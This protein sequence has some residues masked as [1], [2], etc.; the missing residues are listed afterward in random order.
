M[1]KVMRVIFS[2]LVITAIFCS[3]ALA[4]LCG[5]EPPAT[6]DTPADGPSG[7]NGSPSIPN[8]P[9]AHVA[10][11]PGMQFLWNQLLANTGNISSL[12]S[13]ANIINAV[14]HARETGDSSQLFEQ[15]YAVLFPIFPSDSEIARA[16]QDV[17]DFLDTLNCTE[18]CAELCSMGDPHITTADGVRYSFQAVGEFTTLTSD[19]L[20]TELQVRYAPASPSSRSV[21]AGSAIALRVGNSR[22]TANINRE[23]F[24]KF[25]GVPVSLAIGPESVAQ[26]SSDVLLMQL[27]ENFYI[28]RT[29]DGLE[30]R[31]RRQARNLNFGVILP[32]HLGNTFNGIFGSQDDNKENEF[33]GR[34]GSVYPHESGKLSY[35]DLYHGFGNSWRVSQENS[36]FDYEDGSTTIDYTDLTFPDKILTLDD[37]SQEDRARAEKVCRDIGAPEGWMM[38]NCIYDVGF[39][40]DDN[41]AL[42]YAPEALRTSGQLPPIFGAIT[43]AAALT[44]SNN[45][46]AGEK[47]EVSWDIAANKDDAITIENGC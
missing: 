42:G 23:D 31:F 38:D 8:L 36:L 27:N 20:D 34:D 26:L 13:M 35:E 47:F 19:D 4:Q 10:F 25:N 6:V 43:I 40:G 30:I 16:F 14:E 5:Y 17:S 9:G 18:L 32:V 11:T 44:A 22:L 7:S 15:V 28:L 3:P 45:V 1:T 46:V 33:A 29:K 41:F 39:S 21:S 12:T 2:Y 24:I 37:L